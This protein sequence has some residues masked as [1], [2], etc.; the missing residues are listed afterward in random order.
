MQI[1]QHLDQMITEHIMFYY[2]LEETYAICAAT[3]QPIPTR[4]PGPPR[5]SQNPHLPNTPT[6]LISTLI[7]HRRPRRVRR[8]Y[9]HPIRPDMDASYTRR[10]DS[11]QVIKLLTGATA[12]HS[13]QE[14]PI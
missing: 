1:Y 13:Y 3:R 14:A 6:T 10:L 5:I 2:K 7:P 11:T 12:T 4:V 9:A 8:P